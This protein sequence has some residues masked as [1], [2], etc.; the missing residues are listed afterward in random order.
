MATLLGGIGIAHTP[1]MGH[2]FDGRDGVGAMDRWT[3]WF[4]GLVPVKKWIGEIAP[5]HVIVIYNDHLNYFDLSNYPT[6]AIGMSDHFPQADEGWG[7]RPFPGLDGDTAFSASVAESLVADGFDLTF[8]Q[9]LEIDHGIYSWLPC[10]MDQPWPVKF[11][12]IA[13]NM[14]MQP[15]P[16][17]ARLRDLGVALGAAVRGMPGDSRVL[18][19]STGGMSHQIHGQRFGLTNPT[20]DRYFLGKLTH[21]WRELVDIPMSRV[22]QVAGTEAGELAMWYA[23]RGALSE[24]VREVYSFHIRPDITGCGVIAIEEL[25]AG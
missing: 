23:M 6:L 13:V 18:I 21:E 15:V 8:S 5:T 1:S 7:K 4:D 24:R 25:D 10:V 20:F 2:A 9:E 3:R 16:T 22:M 11:L 19:V 14:I 17:P 12:P